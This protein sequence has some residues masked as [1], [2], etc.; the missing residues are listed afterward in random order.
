MDGRRCDGEETLDVGFGWRSAYHQRIGMD[1]GQ[2]LALFV[3]KGWFGSRSPRH[4]V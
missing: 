2:I 4:I 3:G 1:E